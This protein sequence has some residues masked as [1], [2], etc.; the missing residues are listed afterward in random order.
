[1]PSTGISYDSASRTTGLRY[2]VA[3]IAASLF[4]Y[5]DWLGKPGDLLKETSFVQQ[6]WAA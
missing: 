1:M 6:A 2:A 5:A 3:W 4:C